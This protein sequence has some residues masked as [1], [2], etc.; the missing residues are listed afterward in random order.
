MSARAASPV[1]K[2]YL[3]FRH[4]D[5][6]FGLALEMVQELCNAD[7]VKPL[8]A[9]P[10]P[11]AG[12]LTRGGR[13]I[14][15]V[16]LHALLSPGTSDERRA[17]DV[18]ILHADGRLSGV[19]VDCVIDVVVLGE[20]DILPCDTG[21]PAFIGKAQ[22][23]GRSIRLLDAHQLMTDFEPVPTERLAA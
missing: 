18:V 13:R 1:R 15:V 16:D 4:A 20:G 23:G 5:H 14:P 17:A 9:A 12:V 21:E 6:E 8:P 19:A 3:V 2:D 22:L 10:P 11:V 7:I